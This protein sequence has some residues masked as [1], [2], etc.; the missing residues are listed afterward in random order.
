MY[1]IRIYNDKMDSKKKAGKSRAGVRELRSENLLVR[2]KPS[3]KEGFQDAADYAGVP[4]SAWMRER[5][6]QA[7]VKELEAAG[8][9][10]AFL[11]ELDLD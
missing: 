6:R 2:V 5:L 11:R 4:L 9:S 10:I 7:A 3:E 8:R 1:A